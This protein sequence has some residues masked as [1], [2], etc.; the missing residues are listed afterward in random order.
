VALHA[1]LIHW[2]FK[3][4][5][6]IVRQRGCGVNIDTSAERYDM[7]KC[8]TLF[9]QKVL[10]SMAGPVPVQLQLSIC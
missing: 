9:V 6:H 2:K 5:Y 3:H 7:I 4:I 8:A 1:N 10:Q